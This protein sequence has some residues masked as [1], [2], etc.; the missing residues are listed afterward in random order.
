VR[1]RRADVAKLAG[2]SP[3]VVSYVLNGGPR[4]VAPTTRERVLDAVSKLGYR[5]HGIA[6]ALRLNR[7]MTLGLVHP[8]TA[9]PFFAEL[10]RE[11]EEAAFAHGYTL[12]VGNSAEN[13]DRQTAYVRTFLER[14]IDG[15]L[16]IPAHGPLGCLLELERSG[17][18]WV[19][20]DRQVPGIRNVSE[21]WVDN[22]RG[23][24]EAT[25]HLRE[26]GRRSIA[27]IAGPADVP[28]ASDRVSG[29][30]SEVGVSD[31]KLRQVAFG[32]EAGYQAA[33]EL[34]ESAGVDAFFVASDEQAIGA[35]RAI[36]E[37]G[38]RCPDDI[39]LVS[40][41]GITAAEYSTPKI[42]TMAQ[43]FDL[44]ARTA[45][46]LLLERIGDRDA[47]TRHEVLRTTMRRGESCGCVAPTSSL[48]TT[49]DGPQ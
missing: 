9:N 42:T 18:P 28:S 32:R 35:L 11:I 15:L 29:W 14:S 45:I 10:S 46:T 37:S 17:L 4:P 33:R 1:V 41:D 36:Q 3:A 31:G 24:A 39:A 12:L 49:R 40:F 26:H 16:L 38:R 5:P 19:V 7:T 13:D 48:P 34:L 20:V 6:Q 30:R 27:C 21:V 43:P 25:A 44:V 2:T 8:D 22:R 23:A 47:A